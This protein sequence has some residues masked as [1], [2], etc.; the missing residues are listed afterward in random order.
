MDS[1]LLYNLTSI[2]VLF[3]VCG[4]VEAYTFLSVYM[5][6]MFC[7]KKAIN[8]TELLIHQLTLLQ[9]LVSV[10]ETHANFKFV[11]ETNSD[12]IAHVRVTQK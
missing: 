2:R 10:F 1:I 9:D 7:S 8:I 5:Y 6:R 11:L 3:P 12:F 4:V